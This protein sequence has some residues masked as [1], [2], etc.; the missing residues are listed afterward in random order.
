MNV[1]EVITDRI[2][3]MLKDGVVPWRQPWAAHGA[4]KNLVSDKEYRGMNVLLLASQAHKSPYWLTYKQANEAGL[5]VRKG[6]KS[7][8]VIFWKVTD[9]KDKPGEK[10]FILRYYNV[11]N[12][13]Q[14]DG[15]DSCTLLRKRVV[16]PGAPKV[17]EPIQECDNLVKLYKTIPKVEHGGSRA[18]YNPSFDYIGMPAM[19][20]FHGAEE[21]YSTF[22]HELIH[23]TGHKDRLDREGITNP[24]K[25]GSHDYSFEELVAE[26]GSAFLCGKVGISNRVIEN[27]AAYIASWSKKLRSEPRWIV[28]AA[29]KAAKA[30]DYIQGITATKAEK[31]EEEAA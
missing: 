4:P 11:F 23:S 20:D 3:G 18:Y 28:E 12:V 15:L 29:G 16:F 13:G 30:A 25:F 10:G 24:I 8:P 7:T 31:D 5:Q 19:N 27:Q 14:C 1:Y 17:V 26:C 6:E 9:K 21:Y 22:F 2:L